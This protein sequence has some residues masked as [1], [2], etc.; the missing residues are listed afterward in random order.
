[1][2]CEEAAEFV[3][4]LCDG[5]TIPPEAAQHIGACQAC[6]AQL[7]DYVEMGAELR[8][9]ASLESVEEVRALAWDK[10]RKSIPNWWQK[11]WETVRIPRFAFALLIVAVVALGSGLT[12]VKVRAHEQG[13][14]L[15]LAAKTASGH[16]FR[17]AF[18]IEDKASGR[19]DNAEMRPDGGIE[20]YGFRF[21]SRDGD[22]IQLGVRAKIGGTS[23]E[24]DKLPETS[25][26]FHPGEQLEVKV[27]GSEPMVVTGELLDHM[28]PSFAVS[29]EQLDPNPGELRFAAPLLLRGNNVVQDFGFMT[30]SGTG[31]DGG[32]ELCVPHGG[33]Y[34]FSLSRLEGAS[35]GKVNEGR[36]SFELNGQPYQLLAGAPVARAE[37]IWV[38]HVPNEGDGNCSGSGWGPMSQ[39]LPK[40]PPKN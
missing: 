4:A 20:L 29:G 3:S 33:R 31:K 32:I 37:R 16:T 40:A 35:E 6:H 21:I 12:I 13:K 22:R 25:Y 36:I 17:H 28:P 26:W 10:T 15:M 24:V 14:V 39:Y 5:Q 2:K 9:V 8:R 7:K 23:D 11:G 1:M 18:D 34:E 27:E 30:V 19:Q 38:L